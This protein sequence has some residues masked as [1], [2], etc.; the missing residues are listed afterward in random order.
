MRL[1]TFKRGLTL[2]EI[3]ISLALVALIILPIYFTMV[4]SRETVAQS[5]EYRMARVAVQTVIERMR[6]QAS[7]ASVGP[8]SFQTFV[9][10]W[11][12]TA[13]TTPVINGNGAAQNFLPANSQ[14]FIAGLP[15][16][17]DAGN[18]NGPHLQVTINTTAGNLVENL[19]YQASNAGGINTAA[20]AVVSLDNDDD[21][22]GVPVAGL[23]RAVP[24]TITVFW[25]QSA[26][27]RLTITTLIAKPTDFMRTNES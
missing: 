14:F 22:G 9:A 1:S 7:S 5:S 3:A 17:G 19:V 16:R 4:K 27:P 24:V 10:D 8:N 13:A 23:Y 18:I 15:I 25:G 21:A 11:T 20:S 12:A 6:A 26:Q 2:L